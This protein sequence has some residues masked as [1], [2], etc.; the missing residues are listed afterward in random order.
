MFKKTWFFAIIVGA[1]VGQHV[2]AQQPTQ[3]VRG[4]V[5]DAK[6]HETLVGANVLLV[7]KGIGTITDVNGNFILSEIPVGRYMLQISYVGYE[8]I[9]IPELL[10]GSGKEI[11]LEIKMETSFSELEEAVIKPSIRKDRPVNSMASVS[12]RTF[13]VEEASRY[14]GAVDD[15]ARMAG[16]FAGVTTVGANVNAIVVRGNA[17]K[18]LLWRLEGVVIPVPSHFSGSNVAG[19]GALTMFSS[20]LLANSDFYTG[21]FPAEFANATA[22]VFDMKLRSGNNNQRE[23]AFQAGIQGIEAAAE[24]PFKKGKNSSY[25]INYRY[26]TMALIFPLLPEVKGDNEVPVYQDLS[27]KINVP[28]TN[29][30]NFSMWGIG[31]LSKTYMNGYDDPEKWIYPENRV[32][33][34]FH[35]NMG[36]TGLSHTKSISS[37]TFIR[38]T[39]AVNTG[40]H[41]YDKKSRLNINGP[42]ELLPLF[43]V[44]MRSGTATLASSLS[45]VFNERF[46]FRSGIDANNHFFKLKGI[47][48][49][50]NSNSYDTIMDDSNNSW[51]I[52][53]YLQGKYVINNHLFFT[54]GGNASW[55]QLNGEFLLE[56]RF[57]A[58]WQAFPDHRFTLG[59]GSHSQIEPLFVYFVNPGNTGFAAGNELPN[60]RL[61][62]MRAHHFVIGYD[63][64]IKENLHLKIEPYYQY[65]YKVP[66]VTESSYSM[67]NFLSDWTF[68]R[69]LQNKGAGSN[70]GVDLT[71]ERFL[72][73]GYY[74]MS[75]ASVYKSTY[76]DANG[77]I[78]R[79]RYDGGYIL[80]LLGGKEWLVHNKNMLSLNVKFTFMGPYW[81]HPVNVNASHAAGEV[82]YNDD[83]PLNVRYSNLETMTDVT[84]HYRINGQKF[85]SVFSLQVKN[86]VGKQYMGKRYN[87]EN[88]VI[89]D[90]F[91]S[92]PVP[93]VSYKVEF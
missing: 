39:I 35:Y 18:G 48:L 85:S 62:R 46:S 56:P 9:I 70:F 67:L 36:A 24:G 20:E 82:I 73:S 79:T 60:K 80:N 5:K 90:S 14:A 49:D 26:S 89:E 58:S 33:M 87:L 74:Y 61:K 12:A 8:S 83:L 32:K 86:L 54:L 59:Y 27:F 25:L 6:T 15:P 23:Y 77:N 68:D 29:A 30:G 44:K 38:S 13:S 51:L 42:S 21:A 19:G 43:Y 50:R 76:T 57:S 72:T 81:Y 34:N 92:S 71:L 66:V 65:L 88:A 47:A 45:H 3:N 31:G 84:I 64:L 2:L 37:K 53:S 16:N 1:F 75:T 93:F 78:Y 52:K 69:G 22:G 11:V 17:P 55:F 28:G 40:E 41:L 4:T 63:W 91:F 10:V 7:G